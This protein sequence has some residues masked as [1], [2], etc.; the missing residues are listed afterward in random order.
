MSILQ[1]IFSIKNKD[2]EKIITILGIKIRFKN[3]IASLKKEIADLKFVIYNGINKDK[4]NYLI[5]CFQDTGISTEERTPKIIVSLTSFPQRMYEIHYCLYSLLTQSLKPDKVILW[6][7]EEEFPKMEQEL[8]QKVLDLKKH[9]LDIRWCRNIKSYK[10]LVPALKDFSD[11]ILVTADDDVFYPSDWLEKLYYSYL[12]NPYD[13]HCH[14]AHR[15]A[16]DK[17]GNILPYQKWDFCVDNSECSY[18]NFF[19]GVGGVLYPPS[20]FHKDVTKEE[21]F[22]ALAPDA[23]DIWFWAM[24]VL[25]NKKIRIVDNPINEITYINP[26][27]EIKPDSETALVHTNLTGGN[28]IQLKAVLSKYP[29]ILEKLR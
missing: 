3:N 16:F 15:I 21:M 4:I 9:G 18:K 2:C 25:N 19:T 14:R 28:D 29:E 10:K 8:P 7:A 24:L 26:L 11:A 27:R 17:K 22:E 6:L 12:K 5:E 20:S 13:I 23:D 1:N